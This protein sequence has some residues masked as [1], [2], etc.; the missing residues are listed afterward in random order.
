MRFLSSCLR[1]GMNLSWLEL[2]WTSVVM[3]GCESMECVFHVESSH[4]GSIKTVRSGLLVEV[5][6]ARAC[7]TVFLVFTCSCLGTARHEP[8]HR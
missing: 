7:R 4:A 1:V 3:V 6:Q 2:I 8:V 5:E